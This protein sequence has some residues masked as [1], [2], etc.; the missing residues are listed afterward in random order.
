MRSDPKVE[1]T[2]RKKMCKDQMGFQFKGDGIFR[3]R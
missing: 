2:I 3:A 1:D